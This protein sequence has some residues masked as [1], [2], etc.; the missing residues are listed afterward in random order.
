MF[1]YNNVA[2]GGNYASIDL[3]MQTSG[4]GG[5]VVA[6]IRG[7]AEGTGENASDLA[8]YTATG[9]TL[10]ERMRITSGGDVEIH[11]PDSG[12]ITGQNTKPL[13]FRVTQT[14]SQS[15][16]L[17]TIEAEGQ[18]DWGGDLI[19]STK[20][21]NGSPND[22]VVERMRI[23]STGDVG[24]GTIQHTAGNTWRGFFVGSSAS[25]ISRQAPTGTDAM[26]SNN[27]YINSG[28]S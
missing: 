25:I 13:A 5:N 7:L 16:R 3:A 11:T 1:G 28:L 15:A 2:D 4:T 22:T 9:G 17:A 27:L 6:S 23:N 10:A 24:I 26:F 8:F 18:A 14:N 12:S 19:F 21:A 20:S